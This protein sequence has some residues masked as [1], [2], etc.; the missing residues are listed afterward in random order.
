MVKATIETAAK[1]MG[2]TVRVIVTTASRSKALRA[3]P[4]VSLYEQSRIFHNGVLPEL[5]EEML[6]WV[7]GTGASPNRIDAMVHGFT[8]L[9]GTDHSTTLT[10][11]PTGKLAA[12]PRSFETGIKRAGIRRRP[13]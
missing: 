13:T 9:F 2:Q 4:I 11:P 6:T 1:E 5:E 10:R 12:R 8:E 7:P 3:E